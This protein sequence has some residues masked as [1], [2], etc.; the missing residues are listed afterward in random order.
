MSSSAARRGRPRPRRAAVPGARASVPSDPRAVEGARLEIA[1]RALLK[2][3]P[4]LRVGGG[5]GARYVRAPPKPGLGP[6]REALPIVPAGP[7]GPGSH[8]RG[9]AH[10]THVPVRSAWR[11][12]RL[13]FAP[14]A[15]ATPDAPLD[16]AQP[17]GP[18]CFLSMSS[19][20]SRAAARALELDPILGLMMRS[21]P[22]ALDARATSRAARAAGRRAPIRA[23]APTR[24]TPSRHARRGGARHS[25]SRCA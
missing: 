7:C 18:G 11:R 24:R 23:R 5:G 15:R 6:G 13:G 1:R 2:G 25:P 9:A 3:S 20:S 22:R 10:P 21:A 8:P 4:V 17:R 16:V 19:S 14:V 12:R